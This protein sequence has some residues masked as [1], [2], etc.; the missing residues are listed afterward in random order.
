[1]S[2]TPEQQ[3]GIRDLARQLGVNPGSVT[4]WLRKGMPRD[5]EGA[6]AWRQQ[7]AGQRVRPSASAGCD[8]GAPPAGGSFSSWRT[9]RERAQA[10]QAELDLRQ[11]AG[12]LVDVEA[13]KRALSL[14]LVAAR[15]V[16]MNA[17]AR[18]AP[19][20]AAE[21]DQAAVHLLIVTELQAMLAQMAGAAD[22]LGPGRD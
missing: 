8:A 7:H 21:F 18:L 11:R 16:A 12:E 6:R 19:L 2:A 13:V 3:P 14:R 9:R 17:A 4:R 22:D 20:V 15:D 10:M 1:M 5:L